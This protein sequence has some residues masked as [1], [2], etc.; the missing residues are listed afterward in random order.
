LAPAGATGDFPE[1]HI[2][3][4]LNDLKDGDLLKIQENL[5]LLSD[6]LKLWLGEPSQAPTATTSAMDTADVKDQADALD[7]GSGRGG[8]PPRGASEADNR[9]PT[10]ISAFLQS[11]GKAVIEAQSWTRV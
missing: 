9:T 5:E 2:A 1:R 3:E 4:A 8:H 7:A 6:A 11:V 10:T